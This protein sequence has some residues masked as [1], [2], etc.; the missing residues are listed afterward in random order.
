MIRAGSRLRGFCRRVCKLGQWA[1]P[2]PLGMG[3]ARVTSLVSC[4]PCGKEHSILLSR[5]ALRADVSPVTCRHCYL[6][7]ASTRLPVAMILRNVSRMFRVRPT[8]PWAASMP[9]R[10]LSNMRTLPA[11]IPSFP[12]FLKSRAPLFPVS[13]AAPDVSARSVY[14]ETYG[15]QMNA[16]DTGWHCLLLIYHAMALFMHNDRINPNLSTCVCLQKFCWGSCGSMV[17]S[18]HPRQRQPMWCFS[19]RAP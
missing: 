5:A 1:G 7:L 9:E 8:E 18:E 3:A 14:I 11:N 16:N 10:S 6:S 15:C 13:Q 17:M 19:T 4:K 2:G 12:E